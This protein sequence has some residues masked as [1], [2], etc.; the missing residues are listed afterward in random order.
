MIKCECRNDSQCEI[1][2]KF[3]SQYDQKEDKFLSLGLPSHYVFTLLPNGN[4]YT[5]YTCK[6]CSY[7]YQTILLENNIDFHYKENPEGF[8]RVDLP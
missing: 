2:I 5:Y 8:K 6:S 7:Y 1:K 4:E 3:K